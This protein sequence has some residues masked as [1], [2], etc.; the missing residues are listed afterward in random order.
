LPDV[1]LAAARAERGWWQFVT[2]RTWLVG[3]GLSQWLAGS[4]PP[5]QPHCPNSAVIG[6][7]PSGDT[8][9]VPAS[10]LLLCPRA[11]ALLRVLSV[12]SL[13]APWCHMPQREARE[14]TVVVFLHLCYARPLRHAA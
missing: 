3:F 14:N 10:V 5:L 12:L 8:A 4:N 11:P 2:R 1:C 13:A 6:V 7:H 9:L